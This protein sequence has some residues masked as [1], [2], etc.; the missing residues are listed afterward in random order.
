MPGSIEPVDYFAAVD[1]GSPG[2]LDSR[3]HESPPIGDADRL[4]GTVGRGTSS[5][6]P[7]QEQTVEDGDGGL[8]LSAALRRRAVN[9]LSRPVD[10]DL[11]ELR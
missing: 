9:V 10:P 4:C 3:D 8:R 7:E 1:S 5:H 6:L 11:D 2:H